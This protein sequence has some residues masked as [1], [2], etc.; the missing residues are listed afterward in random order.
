[1]CAD[2]FIC[3]FLGSTWHP[4]PAGPSQ[5]KRGALLRRNIAFPFDS[6]RADNAARRGRKIAAT[7]VTASRGW[8]YPKS[9][10]LAPQLI[11]DQGT[12]PAPGT[13]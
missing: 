13:R 6:S 10:T 3:S 5:R 12:A 4:N 8:R 11:A 9:A 7:T 2:H 1:M